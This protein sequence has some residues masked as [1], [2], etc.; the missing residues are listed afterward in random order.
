MVLFFCEGP[1]FSLIFA[2]ALRG[3]GKHT[4]DAAAVLTAAI[5]GGACWP[6]IMYGV[7]T[8]TGRGTQ[9]GYCVIVAAFASGLLLP[10]WQNVHPVARK[11][12]DPMPTESNTNTDEARQSSSAHSRKSFFKHKRRKQGSSGVEHV[13]QVDRVSNPSPRHIPATSSGHTP[14]LDTH[15]LDSDSTPELNTHGLDV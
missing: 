13:E 5:S 4:K 6:P 7:V 15:G 8:G 14:D 1:I 10:L 2:M 9:Y 12:A 3:V 11:L